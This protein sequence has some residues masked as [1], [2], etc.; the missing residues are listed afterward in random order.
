MIGQKTKLSLISTGNETFDKF[1]GG[2]LL[3]SSL[4]LFERKGPSSRPLESIWNKSL[5][6]T[7]LKSG[8]NLIYVNFNSLV[9][10]NNEDFVR[11]LPA[12]R[13]VKS[14][15]LYK[16]I[17]GKSATTKIKIAWRYSS[18]SSSPP[19]NVN[20]MNQIDF[21]FLSTSSL[22]DQAESLGKI[23]CLNIQKGCQL[24]EILSK[25]QTMS[26]ELKKTSDTVNI[27][28]K[29]L[30]HP[31][32][33]LVDDM[34]QICQFLFNLRY[35]A[36]TL[37]KGAILVGYDSDMCIDYPHIKQHIYNLA[38][39]VVKFYSYETEENRLTGYKNTDGTL[40]YLKVPKINSFG[41]HFQ[42]E[43][44]DWGYRLT[45]NHRFFV[46]DEL[47]LPPCQDDD[48]NKMKNQNAA[49]VAKIDHKYKSLEQV[50]PLEDFREIAGNVLAKQL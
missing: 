50:G 5:A 28:L 40:N 11:S 6:A 35:F 44:S 17:R 15:I 20:R 16:D 34:K 38:D 43:L 30:F 13:K 4:N 37:D 10:L 49:E 48:D 29:D 2:G 31:Y 23:S 3:N 19:D 42:R 32:S 9:E 8:N 33:V 14:E 7:T 27:I 41:L 39:C 46:V 18:R 47:S 45:K 12:N 22:A 36:R 1:L 26:N 21:G 25:L 24:K